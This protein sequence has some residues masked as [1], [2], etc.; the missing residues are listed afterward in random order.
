MSL[1]TCASYHCL[2]GVASIW[3]IALLTRVLVR[4]NSL[5]EALYT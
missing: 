3:M 1:L 5:L 2:K 4:T